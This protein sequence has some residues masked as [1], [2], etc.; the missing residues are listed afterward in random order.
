MTQTSH[1]AS[2]GWPLPS[3]T[4]SGDVTSG[5]AS[6]EAGETA[7]PTVVFISPASSGISQPF[8]LFDPHCE[9]EQGKIL[10]SV[11]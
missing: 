6:G 4:P 5:L 1:S 9:Y 2:K 3:L 8:L 10:P 7:D 11:S